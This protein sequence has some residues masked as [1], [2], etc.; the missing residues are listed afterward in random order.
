[1]TTV[2]Y[3]LLVLLL[4]IVL[5]FGILNVNEARINFLLFDARISI[6]LIIFLSFA[7]GSIITVLFSIPSY[8]KRRKMKSEFESKIKTLETDLAQ[9][10]NELKIANENLVKAKGNIQ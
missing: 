8:F 6:A 1:M 7:L 2:R 9:K 5:V 4:L 3:I 10:S